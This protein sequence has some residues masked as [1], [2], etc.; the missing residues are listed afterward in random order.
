MQNTSW[1]PYGALQ[2]HSLAA[3]LP[4]VKCRLPHLLS[5]RTLQFQVRL[6]RRTLTGISPSGMNTPE[7]CK[8]QGEEALLEKLISN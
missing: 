5:F 6:K 3:N 8:R 1:D 7:R 4:L 2:A